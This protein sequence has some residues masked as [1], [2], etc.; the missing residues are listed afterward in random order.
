MDVMRSNDALAE[1]FVAKV[2]PENPNG[3]EWSGV[4][5]YLAVNTA[6]TEVWEDFSVDL[7]EVEQVAEGAWLCHVLQRATTGGGGE[8][9]APHFYTFAFSD[10]RLSRFGIWTDETQA[11]D[12]LTERP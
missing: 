12:E 5:G 6:W 2:Q 1:D 11:R 3:G 7:N 4:D 9:E 10:G 8:V